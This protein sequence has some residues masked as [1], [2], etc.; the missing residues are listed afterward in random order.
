MRMCL[1]SYQQFDPLC[2]D[3]SRFRIV[4]ASCVR[5]Y[6]TT[7]I[8]AKCDNTHLCKASFPFRFDSDLGSGL[9]LQS[10]GC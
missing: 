4:R 7:V 5:A 3:V 9:S 6:S 2:F 1:R 8:V 10:S